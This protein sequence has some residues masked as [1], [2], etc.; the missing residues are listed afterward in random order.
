MRAEERRRARLRRLGGARPRL[1]LA[2]CALI[3]TIAATASYAA[4]RHSVA[5]T[6]VFAASHLGVVAVVFV[7]AEALRRRRHRGGPDGSR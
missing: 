1:T 4:L 6:A 2:L 3:M 7:I 5:A